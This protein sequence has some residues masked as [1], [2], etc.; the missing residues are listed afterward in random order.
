MNTLKQLA[1]LQREVVQG[2]CY[3]SVTGFV[4]LRV[5]NGK[6]GFVIAEPYDNSE[7]ELIAAMRN[8]LPDLLEVIRVAELCV[9]AGAVEGHELRDALAKL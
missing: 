5:L 8:A 6:P 2:H 4:C 3:V 9:C 7:G 1:K